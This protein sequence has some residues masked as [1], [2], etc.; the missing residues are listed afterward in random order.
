[1][2]INERIEQAFEAFH[3][4]DEQEAEQ[5]FASLQKEVTPEHQDYNQ[6]LS[7]LGYYHTLKLNLEQA[8]H[9]YQE[10]LDRAETPEDQYEAIHE[11]GIVSRMDSEFEAAKHYFSQEE[12]LINRHFPDE[13]LLKFI[14]CY[15]VGYV[16]MQEGKYDE[17]VTMLNDALKLAGDEGDESGVGSVHRALGELSAAQ[18]QEQQSK[19]HFKLAKENFK[20]AGD[21]ISIEEIEMLESI[22]FEV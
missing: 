8:V 19:A 1:M 15:E 3:E 12:D 13:Q 10:L 16:Y 5:L 11:L 22:I 20:I 7:A 4:G 17:A 14:N 9:V 21:D 18:G 6:Y 2:D